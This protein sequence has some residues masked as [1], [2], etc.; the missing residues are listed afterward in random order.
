MML[1]GRSIQ[2]ATPVHSSR[3]PFE[4]ARACA[5]FG[6]AAAASMWLDPDGVSRETR[7]RRPTSWPKMHQH[8]WLCVIMTHGTPSLCAMVVNQHRVPHTAKV[9]CGCDSLEETLPL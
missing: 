2:N 3:F 6:P 4:A 5:L 9:V 7:L 1:L 8:G